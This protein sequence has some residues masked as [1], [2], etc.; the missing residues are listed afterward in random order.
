MKYCLRCLY[1]ENHPL[2]IT[3]DEEGVCSGCRVHE[4]KDVL[5]WRERLD[6]LREI[7]KPYKAKSRTVPDC[8]VPVSGG[9]DSYF[10][11]HIVK[12]VLGLKPLLVNYNCHYNTREV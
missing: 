12:E 2:G 7:V 8:I 9:R 11:V 6:K 5:E 10:I 4:E 1:P 3:F